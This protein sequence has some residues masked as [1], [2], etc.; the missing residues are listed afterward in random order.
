[1]LDDVHAERFLAFGRAQ[2]RE[3]EMTRRRMKVTTNA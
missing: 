1:V 2:W 3:E